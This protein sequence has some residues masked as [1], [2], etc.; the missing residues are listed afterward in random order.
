MTDEQIEGDH[1]R[2]PERHDGEASGREKSRGR[3]EQRK[4]KKFLEEN[5][6][7]EGVKTTA[8]GLQYKVLKEGSGPT[9][10][11]TDTVKVNY[12]GTTIDGTEFDSSYKRGEP[13]DV[14]GQSRHQ[15]LDR[16]ASDDEGRFE[17]SA[18]CAGGSRL[19]RTR[20]RFRHRA[21]LR[22]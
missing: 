8:S 10:K 22:R 1:G 7:K 17:I 12:R 13:A 3:E 2:F 9:P 6:T 14:P 18:L 5:K 15:R 11:E 20:R 21:E 16:S 19:R 4:G